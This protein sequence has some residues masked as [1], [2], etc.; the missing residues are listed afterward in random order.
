MRRMYD[1]T[2][3]DYLRPLQ[4]VNV[5]ITLSAFAL[6][7][8]QLPLLA[9][10]VCSRFEL[11]GPA[12]RFFLVAAGAIAVVGLVLPT[13]FAIALTARIPLS[14]TL[15][16]AWPF[17]TALSA[18]AV[19][20]ATSIYLLRQPLNTGETSPANPWRANT[21]EWQISSPP[22]RTNYLEIPRVHHAP[23]EYSSPYAVPADHLPQN[24]PL[25]T[26]PEGPP[27]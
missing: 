24:A 11:R 17:A 9:N 14:E 4:P 16:I 6:G 13:N 10:L 19:G 18:L 22:P 20:L 12:A 8:A 3:Y 26:A 27:Q 23:Y 25:C 21:L 2:Q 7:L 1:T 5:F 15:T